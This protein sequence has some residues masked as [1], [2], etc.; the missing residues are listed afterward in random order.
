LSASKL[1]NWAVIDIETSGIDPMYDTIIDLGYLQFEGTK[2]VKKYSS[3]VKLGSENRD[4]NGDLSFFIQKLTGITPK[5]LKSA[6]SWADVE[7]HLADLCGH[8]LIAH[9]SDF[10]KSFFKKYFDQWS[11]E[12][13][14]DE[15]ETY[16]D[17]LP[18]L[19]IL[20]PQFSSL[21]LEKFICEWKIADKEEHRGLQDSIDLLKVLLVGVSLVRKNGSEIHFLEELFKKY[22]LN[23]DWYCNFLNL[24]EPDLYDIANEIEFDLDHTLDLIMQEAASSSEL[25]FDGDYNYKF[26]GETIK[27]ILSDEEKVREVLPNYS[28]RQGQVD[29]ALKVGQSFKNNIHSLIQA[30]TGTGKTLGYLIPATLFAKEEKKQVLV[31]TGTRALQH[32]AIAKDVPQ[33]RKLFGMDSKKL[34]IKRLIGSNNH[35]CELLFSQIETE[36]DLFIGEDKDETYAHL[37]FERFFQYNAANPDKE[38]LSAGD[39]PFVLKR[40][41]KFLDQLAK[42]VAVDYRACTGKH[43]PFKNDCSYINGLRDAKDADIIIGNHSLMYSW[44]RSLPRPAHIIV[45]EAHKIE[46]G[47]TK[48]FSVELSEE[49]LKHFIKGLSQSQGIGSLYYLLAQTETT[50]GESTAAIGK[51]RQT[52]SDSLEMLTDHLEPLSQSLEAYFKKMPR[53]TDVFWNELPMINKERA[54]D[55]LSVAIY[56]H[57]DSFKHILTHLFQYFVAYQDRWP[58][59]QLEDEKQIVALTRFESFMGQLED[60]S[61]ALDVILIDNDEFSRSLKYH[62]E[63]G[64]ALLAAPIDIG[65]VVHDKLLQTTSSVVFTSATLGNAKGDQGSKGVEWATGY[66]YL[67]PERRFKTGTF[68]PSTYDYKKKTKVYLCDDTLPIYDGQFVEKTLKSIIKLIRNL[69]GSSLLLFSARKRF[70]T[71]REILLKEFEGEIPLFIQ[72]MGNNVVEDFKDAG[73]GVLLG[74]ET[75]GEGIDIPGESLQFVFI[76]KIPDLRMDL[77]INERR[78]FYDKNLGNEF[79]D[80]YLSYRTRSLHQKMGRL[81]RTE[82]D[83]GGVIVVDARIKKWKGRTMEKLNKLMEPYQINRASL[84]DACDGVKNFVLE[85]KKN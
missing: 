75:F 29:L 45:D 42:D 12:S 39:I 9:N 4:F 52:V 82:S 73:N 11:T 35:L 7:D 37:Y 48:A 27:G 59:A 3:L 76:D 78:S 74:M 26:D 66:L 58:A 13:D 54:N 81:L 65:R 1:G 34:K 23:N 77:V 50:E 62:Q 55:D 28:L 61:N 49:E 72:G 80:Y 19:P 43:C 63:Y 21:S 32:Q 70:E 56:N 40:K 71:A 25:S 41:N 68:L 51:I 15:R 60:L 20:H 5:Q 53:F 8:Q 6:P 67:D 38:A 14:E 2:L 84:E 46:E 85:Q 18:F 57:I 44:P 16:H 36:L 79:T 17:S 24:D 69:G 33:L 31:A 30:P 22:K 83:F 10:E 64:F 47:T